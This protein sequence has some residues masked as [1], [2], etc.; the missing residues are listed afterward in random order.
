MRVVHYLWSAQIGGIERL[1]LDLA[2]AQ[3]ARGG[4][5]PVVL[6]GAGRGPF[7][8]RY[9]SAPVEVE[10]GGL[11]GGAD[12][13]PAKLRRMKDLFAGADV[14]HLHAY[15]PL[16]AHA[17]K[18][19]GVPVV[20]TEH[21]AFGLGRPQRLAD[22]VKR[23]LQRRFLN[24]VQYVTFN[25]EHTRKTARS[26]Y[27]L[28]EVP[29]EVIYNGTPVHEA[30]GPPPDP[31]VAERCRGKFVVGTVSR[32]TRP[33]R[34]DRLLD[35]FSRM[36]GREDA[37]LL[38]VGDGPERARLEEHAARLGISGS[39]LFTGYRVDAAGYQRLMD[40]CV[41]PSEVEG[42]GLA[43][44][45][46]LALGKPAVVFRDGGGMAEVVLPH[47]PRDVVSGVEE[48]AVRLEE[49]REAIALGRDVPAERVLYARRFDIGIMADRMRGVYRRVADGQPQ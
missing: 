10:V 43:A 21:G 5:D 1:V 12:L 7:L 27:G 17:A 47:E 2:I 33:K 19:A 37:M 42:F 30:P 35:G 48:L 13:S 49:H 45:E 28:G 16:V 41:L 32:F 9:R 22:G 38:L 44:V 29:Q 15:H 26:I 31:A 24:G 11:R 4:V 14:L 39:T 46:A 8:D 20:Y 23:M 3:R 40:V 18:I 6:L 34:I 36:Q 25:S